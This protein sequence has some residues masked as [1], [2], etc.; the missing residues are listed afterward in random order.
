MFN[1]KRKVADFRD[2][3]FLYIL[4]M[5]LKISWFIGIIQAFLILGICQIIFESIVKNKSE[6]IL[7]F[8]KYTWTDF[9]NLLQNQVFLIVWVGF[10][11][12]N[13]YNFV[14]KL[15]DKQSDGFGDIRKHPSSTSGF[16]FGVN[17][18]KVIFRNEQEF[19]HI[20]LIGGSQSGKTSGVSIPTLQTW[21]GNA[22]VID[23]KDDGEL[24]RK[25]KRTELL[26]KTAKIFGIGKNGYNP[27]FLI[28]NDE[29]N[30]IAHARDLAEILIPLSADVKE[31]IWIQSAQNLL[32]AS[33]LYY[34][35]DNSFAETVKNILSNP[36]RQLV[37]MLNDSNNS[38]IK[39]FTNSFLEMDDKQ[40]A[41]VYNNITANLTVI[42]TDTQLQKLLTDNAQ[43]ITPHDI[44]TTD[45]FIQIPESKIDMWRSVL[46]IIVNQQMKYF[47]NLSTNEI[48]KVK[49]TLFLLEE[50]FRLGKVNSAL[51]GLSTLAS[52][53]V[54]VAIVTQSLGNLDKIYG[55]DG[56]KIIADNCNYK[57]VLKATDPSTQKY[58]SDLL[59]THEVEHISHS[60]SVEMLGENKKSI[61]RSTKEKRVFNPEK[62]GFLNKEV[63]L[64]TKDDFYKIDQLRYYEKNFEKIVN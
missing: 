59:G 4:L 15:A 37:T 18:K 34:Y 22:F 36:P 58:F 53:K 24:E 11:G 16:Y 30:K 49:P 26:G 55:K 8:F 14:K 38:D 42:A 27:Y 1:L 40:L 12:Y 29:E 35:K 57:A 32:T 2:N 6:K 64:I 10:F 33:I 48:E 13:I 19:G 46:T 39:I 31:P 62:L 47:E 21:Q 5:I 9:E 41:S 60:N 44:E 43:N 23:V 45:I 17:G 51:N 20:L 7:S 52:K 28:K 56:T 50:F 54:C 63:V 3:L 61:N 25:S